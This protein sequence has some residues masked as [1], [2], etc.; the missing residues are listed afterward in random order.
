MAKI[1]TAMQWLILKLIRSYQLFISSWLRPCCRFTPT[2]SH[3]AI[4]AIKLHG[5]VKGCCLSSARIIKCNPLS[6]GG[7]DPVPDV[8]DYDNNDKYNKK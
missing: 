6:E 3:Y 2:C 5:I 8:P 7:Y 1:N 4:E